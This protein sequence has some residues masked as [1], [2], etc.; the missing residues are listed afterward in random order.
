ML[1]YSSNPYLNIPNTAQFSVFSTL[2]LVC[3]AHLKCA[4]CD[5]VG[6]F[7]L[8]CGA[9]FSFY[10]VVFVAISSSCD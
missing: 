3:Y 9:H 7:Y 6:T 8:V 1:I 5:L 2:A 4:Y 10:S